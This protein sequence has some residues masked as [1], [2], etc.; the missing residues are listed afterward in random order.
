[1]AL[2]QVAQWMREPAQMP[3]L[4]HSLLTGLET[5]RRQMSDIRAE[6]CDVNRVLQCCKD[7][8]SALKPALGKRRESFN[9]CGHHLIN[10]QIRLDAFWKQDL[11]EWELRARSLRSD[12]E[13]GGW[14]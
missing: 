4:D 3:E 12:M 10:R 11:R 9:R 7:T 1:M 13:L 5:T 6:A 8:S 14:M 2:L